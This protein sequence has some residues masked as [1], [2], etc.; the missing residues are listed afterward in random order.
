MRALRFAVPTVGLIIILGFVVAAQPD[1][2]P[3]SRSDTANARIRMDE[4]KSVPVDRYLSVAAGADARTTLGFGFLHPEADGAWMGQ[5]SAEIS[6]GV[7]TGVTPTAVELELRPLVAAESRRRL[8]TLVSSIDEVSIEMT[9]G[10]ERILLA[11]DGERSQ[12]VSIVCNEVESPISLELNPDR[13][14]FCAKI[15]GYK[16]IADVG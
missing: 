16:V 2:E 6:F 11:L 5:L 15:Y 4:S 10:R 1:R 14:A 7:D 13:R 12:R 3:P 8:V 9:G